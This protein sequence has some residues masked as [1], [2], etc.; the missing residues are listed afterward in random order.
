MKK[1]KRKNTTSTRKQ[2][3]AK[4]AA[5]EARKSSRVLKLEAELAV[6]AEEYAHVSWLLTLARARVPTRGRRS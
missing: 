4:A 2:L 6:I 1:P 5:V 3:L